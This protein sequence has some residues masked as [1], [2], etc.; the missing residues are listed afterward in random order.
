MTYLFV[1]IYSPIYLFIYGL[2]EI[3]E[4]VPIP[5]AYIDYCIKGHV[6]GII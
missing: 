4:L 3:S 2:L 6:T 5:S 1:F